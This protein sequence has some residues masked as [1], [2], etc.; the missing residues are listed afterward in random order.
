ME[1]LFLRLLLLLNVV[2]PFLF[3]MAAIYLALHI[4]FARLIRRPDSPILWFFS[5]VTRPLTRPVR[6]MLPTSAPEAR[7]RTISLAVYVG[8]WIV[9]RSLLV[10]LLDVRPG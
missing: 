1:E 9:T 3:F 6:A 5:V 10:W 7:V 4:L 2:L 8:L